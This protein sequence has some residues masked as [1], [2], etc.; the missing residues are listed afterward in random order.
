MEYPTSE[1]ENEF[2]SNDE[3]GSLGKSGNM[4]NSNLVDKLCDTITSYLIHWVDLMIKIN[5]LKVKS[6]N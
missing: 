5:N 2:S 4:V 1:D 3:G 6:R